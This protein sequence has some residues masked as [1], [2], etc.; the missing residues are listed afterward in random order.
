MRATSRKPVAIQQTTVEHLANGSIALI[1]DA[2]AGKQFSFVLA[3]EA[4][5]VLF[6]Q[7][8]GDPAAAFVRSVAAAR[9]LAGLSPR[10]L[11]IMKLVLAGRANKEIA[12]ALGV[13]QRTVENHRAAIIKKT[14][15]KSILALVRL[16]IAADPAGE[17][18]GG[19]PVETGQALL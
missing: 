11:Q 17:S 18:E 3:P 1:L 7:L 8:A 5:E 19:S 12:A 13:S 9:I 6:D 4:I 2:G 16:L 15:S 10:Q 14:G